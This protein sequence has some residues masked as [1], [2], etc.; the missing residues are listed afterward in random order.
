MNEV[1]QTD[2]TFFMIKEIK[3]FKTQ[4]NAPSLSLVN[5]RNGMK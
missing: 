1:N 5:Q 2:D 4:R 3:F